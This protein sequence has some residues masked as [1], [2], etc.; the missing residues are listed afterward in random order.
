MSSKT[1]TPEPQIHLVHPS[2]QHRQ[3]VEEYKQKFIAEGGTDANFFMPGSGNLKNQGFDD[4]LWECGERRDGWNLPEGYVPSTQFV[5]IRAGDG[6][7]VGMLRIKHQLTP[8]LEYLGG[9]I[10]Y[11]VAPDERRRGYGT[12]MLRLALTECRKL[13]MERV[14]VTC[15]RDNAASLGVI[16]KCGGQYDGEVEYHGELAKYNGKVF[17]RFWINLNNT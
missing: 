16:K 13:G 7:L 4:W 10:G 8:F 1:K 11:S 6:K 15:Q 3:Q 2:E 14:R 9:Q 17:R 12:A 5:G